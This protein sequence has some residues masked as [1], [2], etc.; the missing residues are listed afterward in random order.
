M[1]I[2]LRWEFRTRGFFIRFLGTSGPEV[3]AT[4]NQYWSALW[5]RGQALRPQEPPPSLVDSSEALPG[6]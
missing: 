5:Y 6:A 4:F 2:L 3:E 1:R